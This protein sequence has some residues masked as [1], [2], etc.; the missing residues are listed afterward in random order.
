MGTAN[1]NRLIVVFEPRSNS[2]KLGHG[3]H[4]LAE[5]FKGADIVHV[6]DGSVNWDVKSALDSLGHKVYVESNVQHILQRLLSQI[7]KGDT[8]VFMSNGDFQ[9]ILR[10]F[11]EIL[12]LKKSQ[13]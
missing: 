8:V 7:C 3:K 9:G 5:S 1:V 4:Q 10:A 6:Y 13:R 2:L 11:V 12:A